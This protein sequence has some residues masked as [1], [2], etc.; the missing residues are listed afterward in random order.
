VPVEYLRSMFKLQAGTTRPVD[1]FEQFEAGKIDRQYALD[2]LQKSIALAS[3]LA[4]MSTF[5]LKSAIFP[6][7]ISD[8]E[9]RHMDVDA[10]ARRIRQGG[11]L[12]VY[13]SI[14]RRPTAIQYVQTGARDQQGRSLGF[15]RHI[16]GYRTFDI[17]GRTLR[18]ADAS[19]ETVH[20]YGPWF[21]TASHAVLVTSIDPDTGTITYVDPNYG[22]DPTASMPGLEFEVS[23]TTLKRYFRGTNYGIVV[24]RPSKDV[25]RLLA[26][27]TAQND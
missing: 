5:G 9:L 21:E 20:S 10:F 17:D 7:D 1:E 15:R 26:Q 2:Q 11:G 12:P 8:R 19:T 25:R 4:T 24:S 16:G 27:Q 23:F 3:R 6:V 22:F 14:D 13:L 18:R